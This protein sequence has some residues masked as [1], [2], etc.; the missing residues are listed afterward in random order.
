MPGL[1]PLG[2]TTGH[3]I[4]DTVRFGG[5]HLD[6]I[7]ELREEEF[8]QRRDALLGPED[9]KEVRG[10]RRRHLVHTFVGDEGGRKR[11]ESHGEEEE[12]GRGG[13]VRR[14]DERRLELTAVG[15]VRDAF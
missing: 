3:W 10:G 6:K 2:L 8:W 14:T 11:G 5:G 7:G 1:L 15:R 12:I 4:N 13:S 9:P